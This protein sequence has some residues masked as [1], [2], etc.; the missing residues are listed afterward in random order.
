VNVDLHVHTTFSDGRLTPAEIVSL[1]VKQGLKAIAITDHDTVD[2]IV[3]ALRAAEQF[4]QLTVIPGI[5]IN[6][7]TDNGEVHVLGYFIDYTDKKLIT[8]LDSIRNGRQYRAR[9]MLD[10]LRHLNRPLQWENV[11]RIASGAPICRPHIARAMIDAGYIKSI[12]EAFDTYIGYDCPAYVERKKLFPDE[13]VQ[14]ILN[15]HGLPVLAHPADIENLDELLSR[16]K[17][18]GLAG[19]EVYYKNYT[20]AIIQKLLNLSH[21]YSLTATGGT[22]YHGFGDVQEIMLGK[23]RVPYQC[24]QKLR[25]LASHS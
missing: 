4:P 9:H 25:A 18:S 24:L 21:K 20:R 12:K 11:E 13:A 1:A 23:T 15:A 16:L 8:E 3:P 19:I 7:D 22:D 14:L 6:T 17:K 10:K 5:E 2:G